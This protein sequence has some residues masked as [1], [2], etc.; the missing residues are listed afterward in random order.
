MNENWCDLFS[1]RVKTTVENLSEIPKRQKRS[2]GRFRN[3]RKHKN[4]RRERFGISESTK[5]TVEDLSEIPE[6][7]R[8]IFLFKKKFQRT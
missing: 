4:S 2:L 7:S 3:F 5:M 8:W 1:E 6:A